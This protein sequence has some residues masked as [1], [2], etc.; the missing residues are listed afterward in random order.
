MRNESLTY[1]V[2]MPSVAYSFVS[3]VTST[4]FGLHLFRYAL[5]VAVTNST[6]LV[7]IAALTS[8]DT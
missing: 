5:V 3:F 8:Y 7:E 4:K 1:R 2:H 6:T